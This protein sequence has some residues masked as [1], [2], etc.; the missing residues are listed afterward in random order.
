M[1]VSGQLHALA[2]LPQHPFD[3][4]LGEPQPV[5]TRFLPLPRIELQSSSQLLSHCTDWATPTQACV[6]SL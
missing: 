6:W 1:G 5:W 4:R 2:A 3:K